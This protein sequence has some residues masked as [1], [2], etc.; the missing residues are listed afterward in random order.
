MFLA[1][2]MWLSVVPACADYPM[3]PIHVSDSENAYN[4][5]DWQR[6]ATRILFAHCFRL[7]QVLD[8][9]VRQCRYLGVPIGN[10]DP[11]PTLFGADLLF[12]REL[13]KNGF[14]LWCSRTERPDLGGKEE[15]DNR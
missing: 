14:L 13:N 7:N 4:V 2:P 3:I 11:D 10:M 15:D 5:L 9:V 12:A 8:A 6:I 1:F